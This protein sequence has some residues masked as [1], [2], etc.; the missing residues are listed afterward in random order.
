MTNAFFTLYQGLAREGPGEPADVA[1]AADIVGLKPDARICDAGCGSGADVPALLAAAPQG[2]VTAVDSHKPFIDELWMR[3]GPNPR[4]TAYAGNMA[5]LKGPFDLIWSAGALYFLGV[6]EGLVHWR[7]ALA[8]GG[9]VAFSEPCW[10]SDAPSEGARAFWMEEY[11]AITDADGIDARIRAA[12]FETVAVRRI[13]DTAWA[14]YYDALQ[15][16]VA[17]LRPGADAAL[18]AVL[19]AAQTEIDLWPRAKADS[20]YLLSVVRPV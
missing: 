7:P 1:W 16:R 18:T 13:S 3:I 5:K 4:V 8:K 15:A 19:D 10:F 9:M 17:A 2:K 12:G 20:G 6:T 14:A 11:P